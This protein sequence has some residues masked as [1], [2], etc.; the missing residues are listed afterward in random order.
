[1]SAHQH[2]VNSLD[3]DLNKDDNKN[4]K[5]GQGR[6]NDSIVYLIKDVL[7]CRVMSH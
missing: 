7:S 3:K 1:M 6:K 5:Y 4:D 2:L